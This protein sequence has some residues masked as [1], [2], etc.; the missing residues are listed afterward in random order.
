VRR[1]EEKGITL[2]QVSDEDLAAAHPALASLPR[3]LLSPEGSVANKKSA[4]STSFASVGE[5]LRLARELL[6]LPETG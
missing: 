2:E 5:Q 3:E 4:G 1:C 6:D